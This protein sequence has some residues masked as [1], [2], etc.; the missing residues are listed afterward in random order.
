MAVRLKAVGGSLMA[1]IPA[2]VVRKAGLKGQWV[3][4]AVAQGGRVILKPSARSNWSSFLAEDFPPEAADFLRERPGFL[5]EK[6]VSSG[7]MVF[8]AAA[9]KASSR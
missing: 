2:E 7:G 5:S 3:D 8:S 6:P 4:V 1:I 9:E